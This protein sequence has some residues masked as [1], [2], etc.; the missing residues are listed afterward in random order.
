MN[1]FIIYIPGIYNRSQKLSG[2]YAP[3]L[4]KGN[5]RNCKSFIRVKK[6]TK[7]RFTFMKR[8]LKYPG[9]FIFIFPVKKDN[10]NQ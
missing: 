3:F 1:T 8:F 10:G 4:S 6:T 5:G 9:E 2:F 7:N